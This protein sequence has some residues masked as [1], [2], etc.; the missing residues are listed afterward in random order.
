MKKKKKKR[1]KKKNKKKKL[2]A[3]VDLTAARFQSKALFHARHPFLYMHTLRVLLC[4]PCTL[5]ETSSEY[6]GTKENETKWNENVQSRGSR[7]T[8]ICEIRKKGGREERRE[9]GRKRGR[10]REREKK[11]TKKENFVRSCKGVACCQSS[12]VNDAARVGSRVPNHHGILT[13]HGGDPPRRAR[14]KRERRE[15][16]GARKVELPCERAEERQDGLE[17]RSRLSVW[18]RAPLASPRMPDLLCA[19]SSPSFFPSFFLSFSSLV[20]T[21]RHT[22]PRSTRD[23]R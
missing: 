23:R 7:D 8:R 2:V 4:L 1:N 19:L 5:E 18:R 12:L 16:E 9:E 17:S 3:S 15:S 21:N 6:G 14:V 22:L 11:E 20:R 10:D 13:P